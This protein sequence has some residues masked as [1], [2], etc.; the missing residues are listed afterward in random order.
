MFYKISSVSCFF[1]KDLDH[2]D[3]III[4]IMLIICVNTNTFSN[5]LT[6]TASSMKSKGNGV[7]G[8]EEPKIP[9]AYFSGLC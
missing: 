7:S 2:V 9:A 5:I 4:R 3:L 8:L 6:Y 1:W